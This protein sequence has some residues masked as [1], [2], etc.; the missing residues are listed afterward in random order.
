LSDPD[1]VHLLAA[2]LE[3]NGFTPSTGSVDAEKLKRAPFK[4]AP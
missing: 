1:Y 4:P 3:A 2:I